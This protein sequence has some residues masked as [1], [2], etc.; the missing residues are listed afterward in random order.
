[1]KSDIPTPEMR[2]SSVVRY[3]PDVLLLY[4]CQGSVLQ[5]Q[6]SKSGLLHSFPDHT[7]LNW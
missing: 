4:A 7:I 3:I 6:E 2:F 5:T 1:M